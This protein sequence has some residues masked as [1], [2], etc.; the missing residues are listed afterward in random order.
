M[1]EWSKALP[2]TAPRLSPPLRTGPNG[3]V[4]I[5]YSKVLPKSDYYLCHSLKPGRGMLECSQWFEGKA[6]CSAGNSSF[7]PPP[8]LNQ[9]S[10]AQS[11]N[12]VEKVIEN[13][14]PTHS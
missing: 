12:M 7:T 9:V 3:Q 1:N 5:E 11:H 14:I 13:E 4:G 8:P 2:L 6:V 10:Y